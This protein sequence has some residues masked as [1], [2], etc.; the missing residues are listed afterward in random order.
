MKDFYILKILDLF[1]GIYKGLGIN[2]EIMR[3]IVQSKLIM[4][5]RRGQNILNQEEEVKDKN[6]FYMSLLIYA[7]VGLISAPIISMD[8]NPIIKMSLYFSF[9]M[10]IILSVF[11]SDFSSV[12][13]DINDKDIIVTK[14]VDLKTLNAAKFTHIFIY[15]SQLSLAICITAVIAGIRYGPKFI[16]LFLLSIILIDIL[17][18][19][20]TALMYFVILK[21]FSG[22]KLKDMIN[23]FQ[24]LFLLVFIVGYQF[25]GRAFTFVDFNFV[26]KPSVW[27]LL[28]PPMWFASNFNIISGT[29]V[30]NLIKVMSG[31]SIVIPIISIIAYIKLIPVF[32]N[33]LQ[34]LSD[35][36]Y[37]SKRTKETISQK[38]SKIICK[39][40][41]ERTFFN[42]VY[43]VLSKDREF[44]T[45]IYPSLAM[46]AFMPF[47]MLVSFY[48]GNGLVQFLDSLRGSKNYFMGYLC[49]LM[50]QS[51][52]TT[53]KFSAQYEAAWIY[54]VLPI[55]EK[56]NVYKGMFKASIYKLILPVF[57][58]MS[59]GF[60]MLFGINVI[61]HLFIMFVSL[62]ITSMVTF[63][64]NHKI[65]P[66]SKE[67]KNTNSSD[68]IITM[69]KAMFIVGIVVVIHLLVSKSMLM[70][71]IYFIVLILF[72]KLSW[73]KV[74]KIKD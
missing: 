19:I 11:I 29:N 35:N 59:M 46:G 70:T 74:F 42:F 25:V 21:I 69:F 72:I 24:I 27:H 57:I 44:K 12:I 6:S 8:T 37:K 10:V 2:Y 65:M 1:K 63:K 28:M 39:N 20:I 52:I 73:N 4:D 45:K 38:M 36:T 55:K 53:L 40:K 26:Y 23:A 43:D 13:L 60:I 51:I 56:S 62:I 68:N 5:G 32:E 50:S 58:I 61:I 54:D 30:D 49:V 33:N 64:L 34:K 47:I 15:I 16:V 17:M 9:F 67:Y 22:E 48:D 14:G 3:V 7:V 18:I 71:L 66:F 31:L 41:E